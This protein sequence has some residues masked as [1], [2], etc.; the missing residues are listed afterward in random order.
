LQ[1]VVGFT[2]ADDPVAARKLSDDVVKALGSRWQIHEVPN[3][4]TSGAFPL[5]HCNS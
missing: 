3:V 5:E 2:K 4:E 1:I